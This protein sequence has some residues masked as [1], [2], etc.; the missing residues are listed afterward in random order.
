MNVY[1]LD[2]QSVICCPMLQAFFSNEFIPSSII[3]LFRPAA[4]IISLGLGT[5][6]LLAAKVG[7]L[8]L[9]GEIN[10]EK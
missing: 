10:L 5:A 8:D 6:I 9:P 1:G 3:H 4:N 2:S 7:I